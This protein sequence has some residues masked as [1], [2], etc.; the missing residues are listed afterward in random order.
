MNARPSK[1][2]KCKVGLSLSL[3]KDGWTSAA[4]AKTRNEGRMTRESFIGI[5]G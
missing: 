2:E 3:Y 1:I 4:M 5:R